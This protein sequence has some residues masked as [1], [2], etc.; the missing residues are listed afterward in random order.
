MIITIIIWYYVVYVYKI[1][2]RDFHEYYVNFR[3]LVLYEYH[4]M[5]RLIMR[6]KRREVLLYVRRSSDLRTLQIIL[7]LRIRN[8]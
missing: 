6:R 4:D 3:I 7:F 8:V 5:S 2:F 1:S